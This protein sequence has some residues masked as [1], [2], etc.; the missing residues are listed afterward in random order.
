MNWQHLKYFAAVAQEEHFTRAASKLFI[1]QSTLS[2]AMDNLEKEVGV[3]LFE[4]QG[5]NVKLTSFGKVLKENVLV[6]TKLIDDAVT[7]INDM[8]NSSKGVIRVSSI[9]TMG[10][11]FMPEVL[12]EY[13]KKYN[14][15]QLDYAQ[16]ATS[17]I[18][19]AVLNEEIDVGFCGDFLYTEQLISIERQLVQTEELVLIVPAAH[20]LSGSS[21]VRMADVMEET[22]IG[23][24]ASTGI[25]LSIENALKEAGLPTKLNHSFSATEDNTVV[26]LVRAELGIALVANVPSVNMDGVRKLKVTDAAMQ[27]SLFMIWKK[28]RSLS[29]SIRSFIRFVSERGCQN[30]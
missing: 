17:D 26:G 29:T 6:A 10:S 14:K 27:R 11:N 9:F 15:V 30:Y 28:N 16:N 18:I 24:N 4:K 3:P 1:T 21:T 5:R 2:K 13:L 25:V 12:H 19:G 8:A 23:W 20:P 7:Q 22:F